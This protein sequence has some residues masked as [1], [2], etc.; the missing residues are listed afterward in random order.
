MPVP[1]GVVHVPEL[2]PG[3]GGLAD[4]AAAAV[5]DSVFQPPRAGTRAEGLNRL[6]RR[7]P[8]QPG[9]LLG[10][11]APMHVGVRLVVFG[12]QPRPRRQLGW[13]G[14]PVHVA[15][16]GHEYGPEGGSDPRDGLDRAVAVVGGQPTP[17]EPGEQVDLH[18][19]VVDQPA[20]RPDPG[21]VRRGRV[22]AFQQRGPGVGEQGS[23]IN[24]WMPHL[25]STA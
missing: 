10:D 16:L 23:D 25:A 13:A 20:Q 17:D 24:T 22:Q 7:P 11:P 12:G 8:D 19:E 18:I 14:E 15:D 3:G 21:Q 5:P 9:A 1:Q 2:L 6:D 4:V